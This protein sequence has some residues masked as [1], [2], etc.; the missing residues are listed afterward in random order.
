MSE[1]KNVQDLDDQILQQM[2]QDFLGEALELL[3]QLNLNLIQLED[4][5]SNQEFINLIFRL[6]H[7]IKGSAAFA[8]LEEMS[9]IA[10][11]MEEIMGSFRK[12]DRPVSQ[13]VIDS[14][15]DAME[16]LSTL[17]DSA[18]AGNASPTDVSAILK[19]LAE[20]SFQ[21]SP[22]S[23]EK[24]TGQK[25]MAESAEPEGQQHVSEEL[26]NIYKAG[27]D[28]LSALKHLIYSSIHLTDDESLAVLVSRQISKKMS[29]QNN[30]IWLVQDG[31]RVTDVARN[32]KL[33]T[34][35]NRKI[36]EIES[37]A[38]LQKVVNEQLVCW[39]SSLPE[40]KELLPDFTSPMIIPF[41]AQPKSFGFMVIDPEESDEVEIYQFVGQF[42]AII[43]NISRLHQK[44][45][46]QR[47]E[48]DE[49]T[50][51][52]F[53]QNSILSSLYHVELALMN[54]KNPIDLCRIV[55]EAFVHDLEARSAA[56]FLRNGKNN[57]QGLWGSGIQKIETLNFTV[58]SNPAI[59]KALETGRIVSQHDFPDKLELGGNKL[60]NW[61]IMCLKGREAIHGVIISELDIDDIT[62]SMSILANYSGILLDNLILE[63]KID[64]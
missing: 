56:I 36:M 58:E 34:Q 32:G 41:K 5:P 28:H 26:F 21:D 47:K 19:Q 45:E 49:M 14:M 20:I 31:K 10:R 43:L 61:I 39:A 3:D 46:A 6:V 17:R 13:S 8:G 18:A 37:S 12:G 63:N 40:L 50:A 16:V 57:L 44:V 64:H 25:L 29:S 51:I 54:I 55:A 48:L 4:D 60:D 42:A 9:S 7:T 22:E 2:L 24:T 52:L 11:K 53:R 23:N 30:E 27:Y 33:I 62:D 35:E 15:F 38:V 59:Q 1:E